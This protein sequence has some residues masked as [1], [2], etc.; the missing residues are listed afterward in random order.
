MK[1]VAIQNTQTKTYAPNHQQNGSLSVIPNVNTNT[2][3][4]TYLSEISFGG[5]FKELKRIFTEIPADDAGAE[6]RKLF[7]LPPKKIRINPNIDPH[8]NEFDGDMARN[9]AE[10][11]FD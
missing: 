10:H 8:A 3:K 6:L 7:D 2:L 9:A 11:P 1:I 4:Q 5:I